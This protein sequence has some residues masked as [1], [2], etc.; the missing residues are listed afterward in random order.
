ML[1]AAGISL[2]QMVIQ[3]YLPLKV[4]PQSLLTIENWAGN[5]MVS[6][7]KHQISSSDF[8][9]MMAPQK[10]ENRVVFK[11]T[12]RFNNTATADV[13]IKRKEVTLKT[14]NPSRIQH[15]YFKKT[16]CSLPCSAEKPC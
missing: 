9:Y 16:D 8:D 7:E 12:D 6:S 15:G 1:K 11:L 13:F 5:S 10:G 14:D 2:S 3:Y 4:E